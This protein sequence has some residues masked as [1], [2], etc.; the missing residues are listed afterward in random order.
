MYETLP[1]D[2]PV[3]EQ[4]HRVLLV[5][6]DD[7]DAFLVQELLDGSDLE[8][9][10]VRTLAEARPHLAGHGFGCVLLDLGLPDAQGLEAV[11]EVLAAGGRAVVCLTGLTDE[12]RGIAAMAAG[13]QDY[14]IKGSVD[15]QLLRRSVRYAIERRR[16]DSSARQLFISRLR[17]EEN[18]RLERGLLPVPQI[19]DPTLGVTARYRPR[20]GGELGGDFYD[21]VETADGR[22]FVLLGDVAGHGPDEAALGV[23]LRIAWRALVLAG[24]GPERVLPVLEKVL[25]RER[26][27]AEIFALASM[28]VIAADRRSAML[29]LAAHLPPMLLDPAPIQVSGEL[30]GPALGLLP[31]AAWR[32]LA[33]ALPEEWRLMLYTDGL[34]EGR[35][36]RSSQILG[37]PG[38]LELAAESRRLPGTPVLVDD[39]LDRVQRACGGTMP[40]DV[41]VVVLQWPLGGAPW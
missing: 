12:Q 32:G 17:E 24:V 35:R 31:D 2:E 7:G 13:A 5:E 14:L 4:E 40:D 33:V 34:V 9:V 21:V 10:R 19:L 6:D 11:H 37:V 15:G 36:G 28:L 23:S 22:V 3:R 16:A 8:L 27:S 41:A 18:A 26:R 38:L 30:T 39:L 1:V 20:G 25:V 29:W